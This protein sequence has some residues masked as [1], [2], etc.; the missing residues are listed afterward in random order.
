MVKVWQH[1]TTIIVVLNVPVVWGSI[2][3]CSATSAVRCR[4]RFTGRIG[5]CVL[6]LEPRVRPRTR[7]DARLLGPEP[8]QRSPGQPWRATGRV[9]RV[10]DRY[11][12]HYRLF[13]SQCDQC[14]RFG[15]ITED[16]RSEQIHSEGIINLVPANGFLP[17]MRHMASFDDLEYNWMSTVLDSCSGQG[18]V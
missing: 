12:K 15:S 4:S 17:P 3:T 13:P 6:A 8:R 18:F 14:D 1:K 7:W 5:D 11:S 2:A 16:I 9:K 10:G